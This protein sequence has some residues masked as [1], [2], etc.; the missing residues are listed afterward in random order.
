MF[1]INTN[2]LLEV[3]LLKNLC[4]FNLGTNIQYFV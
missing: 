1:V 3:L 4:T 2:Q